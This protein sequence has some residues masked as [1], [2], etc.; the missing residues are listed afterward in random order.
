MKI[1]RDP[2]RDIERVRAAREAIGPGTELFVDA[3]GAYSRKQALAMA[4]AFGEFGV[5]WFE[6]PVSSDD[7]AGLRLLR[8]R[9]PP[10]MDIAV[11]EWIR[12]ALF[13][14]DAE[15]GRGRCPPGQPPRTKMRLTSVEAHSGSHLVA[16]FGAAWPV[17]LPRPE[18]PAFLPPPSSLLTVAQARRSASF[19]DTPRFS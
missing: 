6:E 14:A 3:N 11:G 7:L 18:P 2:E 9:A 19:P 4:E 16:A 12:S 13:P 5:S 1:G 15:S 10:G 17:D 8:D